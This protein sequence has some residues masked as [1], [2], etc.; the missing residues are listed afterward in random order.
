MTLGPYD[1]HAPA[2]VGCLNAAPLTEVQQ[3]AAAPVAAGV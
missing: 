1:I 2:N 3:E